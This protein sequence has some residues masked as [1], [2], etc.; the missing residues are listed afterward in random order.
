[1]RLV[2]EKK[3][4]L[5]LEWVLSDKVIFTQVLR[6]LKPE[7]FTRPLDAV[8][9]FMIKYH[10]DHNGI[11]DV[12]LIEAEVG[13]PLRERGMDEGERSYFLND[14]EQ[15]CRRA[16]MQ[17]ALLASSEIINDPERLGE[18]ETLVRDALLV[19]IDNTIGTD[20][21]DNPLGRIESTEEVRDV[22]YTGIK[23]IDDITGGTG[24]G[25]IGCIFAESSAGK[26][27]LLANITQKLAADKMDVLVIS[28]EMSENLYSQRL[29]SIITGQSIKEHSELATTIA[30]ELEKLKPDYGKITV[31]RLPYGTT[32]ADIRAIAMEYQ[33]IYGKFP[34][35]FV[36]DY[37][38]LMGSTL[39]KNA[40]KF[41]AT[42]DIAFALKDLMEDTSSRCFT[43]GQLNRE[44]YDVVAI[45]PQHVAGGIS[46]VNALDWAVGLAQTEQDIENNQVQAVQMKVRSHDKTRSP[47]IIYRCP[48]TLI[49]QDEPFT[50]EQRRNSV[51][52]DVSG[53]SAQA[54]LRKRKN[55]KLTGQEKM[56]KI[57]EL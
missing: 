5:L 30:D 4:R 57:L 45:R 8:V 51:K 24:K 47:S 21:F 29:D 11:P 17:N 19:K 10:Q 7:Y 2:I 22:W 40:G 32:V 36:V 54:V 43:A 35:A 9:E 55:G 31:K 12:D 46:L 52:V 6:I 16:A 15:F 25:E 1:M 50:D 18:A 34:D 27:V 28:L 37:L 26:S 44:G 48:K 39:G 3:E 33:L 49:M 38:A 20:I 41:E 14:I 56:S 53:S 13:V 42:E 23:K